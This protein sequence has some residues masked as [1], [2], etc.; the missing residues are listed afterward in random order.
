MPASV[1]ILCQ[2]ASERYFS[3]FVISSDVCIQRTYFEPADNLLD[4]ISIYW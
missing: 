4:R 2:G 1:I 3:L